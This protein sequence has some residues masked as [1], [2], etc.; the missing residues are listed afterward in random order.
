MTKRIKAPTQMEAIKKAFASG[1]YL[2]GRNA[3]DL[4]GTMNLIQ[5]VADIKR[6]GWIIS[7]KFVDTTTMFGTPCQYKVYWLNKDLTPKELYEPFVDNPVMVTY[8][9]NQITLFE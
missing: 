7:S 9:K 2:S 8:P 3:L 6:D 1:L 5:R 4:T